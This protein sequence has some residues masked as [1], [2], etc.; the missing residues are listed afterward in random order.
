MA[1]RD[2]TCAQVAKLVRATLKES[3][4]DVKFSVHTSTYHFGHWMV[5]AW[6]DGPMEQQVANLT[7]IFTGV[8]VDGQGY[9]HKCHQLWLA[10][11][12]I[13]CQLDR[14]ATRRGYTNA[15]IDSSIKR[16]YTKFQ[17]AFRLHEIPPP[18][19]EAYRASL[20]WDRKIALPDAR[21]LVSVHE[22]LSADMAAYSSTPAPAPS[23]TLA[24]IRCIE[25]AQPC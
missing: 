2:S 6:D 16:V 25:E 17:D 3:F 23:P 9:S 4:A 8:H 19:V 10:G 12:R 11:D 1:K 24:K 5:I 21:Q 22:L 18:T 20:L 7:S 13:P 15:F 14:V